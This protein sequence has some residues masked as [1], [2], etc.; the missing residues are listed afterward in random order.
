M[1]LHDL[2][3]FAHLLLFAYWLGS[4]VGVFYGITFVLRPDL[5]PETRQTVMALIHWID[6]IPRICF[7]LMV[8][9]GIT[10]SVSAGYIPLAEAQRTPVLA[11]AWA[12]GLIWLGA[13]IAAYN[14]ISNRLASAEFGFRVLLLA[15]FVLAGLSSL[16]GQGPVIPGGTWLAVKLVLFGGIIGCSLILERLGKPMLEAAGPILEGRS[17]L[18]LETKLA[19]AV[20]RSRAVVVVL[21]GLIAILGFLGITKPV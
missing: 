18:A 15:G 9:L 12:A 6:A 14:G 21:W 1:T 17:T 16:A 3:L 10:L 20:N 4:D 19:S 13:S 11:I 5:S 2:L 8:P 7:V